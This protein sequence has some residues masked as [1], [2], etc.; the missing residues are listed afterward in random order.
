[1]WILAIKAKGKFPGQGTLKHQ[2]LRLVA[3]PLIV[4]LTFIAFLSVM[5]SD[6][7][8]ALVK[9]ARAKAVISLLVTIEQQMVKVDSSLVLQSLQIDHTYKNEYINQVGEVEKNCRKLK[10]LVENDKEVIPLVN[11]SAIY[12]GKLVSLIPQLN[13]AMEPDGDYN[14]VEF[15]HDK[16]FWME[17]LHATREYSRCIDALLEHYGKT[18]QEVQ[19]RSIHDRE[20]IKMTTAIAAAINIGLALVLAIHFSGTTVKRLSTLMENIKRFSTGEKLLEPLANGD[21]ISALDHSFREMADA[22]RRAETVR[23]EMVAMVSHDLRTPL[24]G[25]TGFVTLLI[26]GVYGEI[27]ERPKSILKKMESEMHRLIRL[28]NDLL[29]IEKIE[30][31]SLE[32]M[33]SE[34]NLDDVV[35]AAINAVK[36]IAEVKE[37]NLEQEFDSEADCRLDVDRVIQVLVNLLSNSIKFSEQGQ[38]VILRVVSSAASTRFEVEDAG[39]G[40]PSESQNLVFERFKQLEQSSDTRHSGSGLGLHICKSIVAAHGGTIGVRSELGKGACFW[41]DLP[42]KS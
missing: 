1:M 3:I 7:E 11:E 9:E 36:G 22:R 20:A 19:P 27:P 33:V 5:I 28:A 2:A 17:V 25:A 38:T 23:R 16:D 32:L 34:A 31:N 8:S 39:P 26:E 10:Q 35:P 40:I 14:F 4:E 24:S 30:S 42:N 6:L 15:L 21:E 29:D 18:V 37:V 12:I 13:E 41:F